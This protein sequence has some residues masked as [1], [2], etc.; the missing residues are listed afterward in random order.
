MSK[1]KVVIVDYGLGNLYNVQRALSFVG[2]SP[3]ISSSPADILA[4][5]RLLIPGVG[6][7]AEGMKGLQDRKL[8][9]PI[10]EVAAKGKPILGICLGA[11]L[12]LT[13]GEEHGLHAGLGLIGGTVVHMRPAAAGGEKYKLPHIGWNSLKIPDFAASNFWDQSI[14]KGLQNESFMYFL[15]SY[16]LTL[17]DQK[18]ALAITEYGHDRFCS[19]FQ[20]KKIVG[21]QPHPE[22]SG[23]MGLQIFRNFLEL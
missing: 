4:A 2:A 12:L 23:E 7:F 3:T 17:R 1:E 9:E 6:A 11:Q 20:S 13:Q 19:V 10:N 8:I 14:L 22:R 21:F 18:S 15:H 5:D 16:I